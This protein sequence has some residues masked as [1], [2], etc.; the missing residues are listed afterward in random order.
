VEIIDLTLEEDEIVLGKNVIDLTSGLIK[1]RIIVDLTEDD[2]YKVK[3]SKCG[4]CQA[5]THV[6]IDN[7]KVLVED[8]LKKKYYFSKNVPA[9]TASE[10][11]PSVSCSST[12]INT[13]SLNIVADAF[14]DYEYNNGWEFDDLSSVIDNDSDYE[15]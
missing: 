8:Y 3:C 10:V 12:V 7:K 11:N 6:W 9:T 2:D 1:K 13:A 15:E 5:P 14:P 4:H